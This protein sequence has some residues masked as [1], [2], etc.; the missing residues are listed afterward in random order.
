MSDLQR[1]IDNNPAIDVDICAGIVDQ[2]APISG[3]CYVLAARRLNN[4]ADIHAHASVYARQG[5]I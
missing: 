3:D 5:S 4:T 2:I 1:H